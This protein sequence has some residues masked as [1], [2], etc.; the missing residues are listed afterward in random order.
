MHEDQ[1]QGIRSLACATS[2]AVQRRFGDIRE[3]LRSGSAVVVTVHGREEMVILRHDQAIPGCG[4]GQGRDAG[5]LTSRPRP[6]VV[7]EKPPTAGA[8]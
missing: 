1:N 4:A 8:P 2:A 5:R 6:R 3:H 7:S